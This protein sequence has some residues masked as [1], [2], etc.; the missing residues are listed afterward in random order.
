MAINAHKL[1]DEVRWVTYRAD[2]DNGRWVADAVRDVLAA[3]D[4]R[5]EAERAAAQ[6]A[7][8]EDLGRAKMARRAARRKAREAMSGGSDRGIVGRGGL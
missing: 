5:N 2:T 3:Y 1:I 6:Y 4:K 7:I 8:N